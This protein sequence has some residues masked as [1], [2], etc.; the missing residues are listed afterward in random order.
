MSLISN[1]YRALNAKEHEANN[2]YGVQGYKHLNVVLGL[3]EQYGAKDVLDYGCGGATLSQHAR[4]MSPLPFHNYDPAIEKYSAAPRGTGYDM[5]VCTDVLEH[6][7]PACLPEVLRHLSML[8]L[9]VAFIEVACRPA[10]RV[11][12]DGR[13][14]HLIQRDGMFWLDSLRNHFDV[15]SFKGKPGHSATFVLVPGGTAWS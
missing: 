6:I 11:L 13:N 7:E 14:A 15:V 2:G 4:K 5:V 1:E 3:A 10:K 8:T 9:K 12:S